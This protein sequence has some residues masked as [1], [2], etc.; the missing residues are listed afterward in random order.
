M[1]RSGA[2][3]GGWRGFHD[4]DGGL[5]RCARR[6][7]IDQR[8]GI[9]G[10][11]HVARLQARNEEHQ[12]A[13]SPPG[14]RGEQP[15]EAEKKC[16][17]GDGLRSIV[18]AFLI[19]RHVDAELRQHRRIGD[20]QRLRRS[21]SQLVAFPS[22]F[23]RKHRLRGEEGVDFRDGAVSLERGV[24]N[25]EPTIA[26]AALRWAAERRVAALADYAPY[27]AFERFAVER[28]DCVEKLEIARLPNFPRHQV[29]APASRASMIART[30]SV[31]PSLM[32]SMARSPFSMGC[33]ACSH[34]RVSSGV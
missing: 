16:G 30:A 28:V 21:D 25:I 19:G 18:S 26:P 1:S 10:R 6:C 20:A 11:F 13:A 3:S 27:F 7:P 22:H 32:R 23:G 33:L 4:L 31:R 12:I 34:R 2:E 9:G 5:K 8:S 24:E 29:Y 17:V 15:V 14:A